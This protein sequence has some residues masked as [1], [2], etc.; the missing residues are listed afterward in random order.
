MPEIVI[1]I[2]PIDMAAR[3]SFRMSRDINHLIADAQRL[4]NWQAHDRLIDAI[5]EHSEIEAPEGVDVREVLMDYSVREILD[6]VLQIAGG[7]AA[8]PPQNGG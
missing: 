8:V 6:L 2:K 4:G 7:R 3:G 1:T 5:I